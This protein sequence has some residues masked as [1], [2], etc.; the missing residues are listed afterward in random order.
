MERETY[1]EH[2]VPYFKVFSSALILIHIYGTV[3]QVGQ[4]T[5]SCYIVLKTIIFL[6]SCSLFAF[7]NQHAHI[8]SSKDNWIFI[9]SYSLYCIHFGGR[10]GVFWFITPLNL[11]GSGWYL[12][13]KWG[14][15]MCT[16]TKNWRKSPQ[17][18]HLRVPE[19]VLFFLS[20]S[21]RG[22]SATYPAPILTIFEANNM[23]WCPHMYT[24]EKI[25][26]FC[27]WSFPGPQNS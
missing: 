10:G 6:L 21:Q 2:G 16:H 12:E 17:G 26:I 23:N 25:P 14:A 15:M 1:P 4:W 9:G 18:F 7:Q 19:R 13:Y 5:H 11:N 3:K 22:L 8:A 20:F 24:S 27:A